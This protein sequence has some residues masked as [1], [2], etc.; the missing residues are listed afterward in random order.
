MHEY[1]FYVL[2]RIYVAGRK[3]VSTNAEV[4]EALNEAIDNRDEGIMIKDP[5]TIYK[6]GARPKSGWIKVKPDYQN[7]TDTCDLIIIGGYYA[8]GSKLKIGTLSHFLC[9]VKD[10]DTFRS[11]TRVSSGVSHKELY[12]LVEKLKPHMRPK[13]FAGNVKYGK[14]KPD[15]KIDPRKSVVLEIRAAEITKSNTYD[16]GCTLRYIKIFYINDKV[17]FTTNAQ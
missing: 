3:M 1:L 12:D 11:F 9:A 16:V 8:S 6:P 5:S 17:N 10:G 15:M 13:P 14:E 4:Q 7:L 2:G